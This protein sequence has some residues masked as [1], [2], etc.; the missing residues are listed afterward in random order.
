MTEPVTALEL[1]ISDTLSTT[2]Y[3]FLSDEVHLQYSHFYHFTHKLTSYIF[4]AVV[5]ALNTFVVTVINLSLV[6]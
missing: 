6:Q 2:E 3:C 1:C 5:F 4:N